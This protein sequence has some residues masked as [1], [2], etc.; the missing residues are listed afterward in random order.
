MICCKKGGLPSVYLLIGVFFVNQQEKTLTICSYIVPLPPLFGK[1]IFNIQ[2]AVPRSWKE[3]SRV[4][5]FTP[6]HRKRRKVLWRFVF[7]AAA[8]CIWM[9]RNARIFEDKECDKEG[10]WDRV[11]YLASLWASLSKEFSGLGVDIIML[12]WAEICL[13]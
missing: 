12:N 11:L 4:F 7:M 8:W 10:I 13:N 5:W 2:D 6:G 3:F 1:K 9:Q